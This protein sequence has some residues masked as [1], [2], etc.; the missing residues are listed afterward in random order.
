MNRR[1]K[2]GLVLYKSTE[3]S[4]NCEHLKFKIQFIAQPNR[5]NHIF[6]STGTDSKALQH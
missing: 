4:K 5:E 6:V 1:V 2:K 3:E